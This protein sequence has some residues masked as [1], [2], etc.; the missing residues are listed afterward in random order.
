MLW[1]VDHHMFYE[2]H[3]CMILYAACRNNKLLH[4]IKLERYSSQQLSNKS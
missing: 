4:A 3:A 2:L 1:F